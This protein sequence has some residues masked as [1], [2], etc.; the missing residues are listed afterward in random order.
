MEEEV[1]TEVDE[2][3][4]IRGMEE[5]LDYRTIIKKGDSQAIIID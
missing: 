4:G 2:Y 1:Q 3:I 5:E